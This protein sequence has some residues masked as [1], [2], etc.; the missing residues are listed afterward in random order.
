[1]GWPSQLPQPARP[2]TKQPRIARLDENIERIYSEP[3]KIKE[4]EMH[5]AIHALRDIAELAALGAFLIMIALAARA[6]GA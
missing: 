6:L 2:L 4:A 1:V 5:I 3:I